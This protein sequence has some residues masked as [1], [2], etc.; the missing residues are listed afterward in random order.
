[1]TKAK[2][3]SKSDAVREELAKGITAPKDV[4]ANLAKRG[5]QVSPALVSQIKGRGSEDASSMI[6]ATLQAASENGKTAA[7]AT[8]TLGDIKA[9]LEL[10]RLIEH[11]GAQRLKKMVDEVASLRGG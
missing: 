5:I 3:G 2:A 1:M 10:Q 4:V 11:Y 9:V 7:G 6:G 8:L